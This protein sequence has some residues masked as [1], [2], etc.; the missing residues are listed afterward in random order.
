M[1]NS[2]IDFFQQY[3]L[4]LHEKS[5]AERKQYLNFEFQSSV[6]SYFT[7]PEHPEYLFLTNIPVDNPNELERYLREFWKSDPELSDLV[8]DL[9]KVAYQLKMDNI[10]ASTEL[11]PFVYAMF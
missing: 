5:V 9:V 3:I 11:S 7:A 1:K 10:E 8:P 6:E 4:P 2:I